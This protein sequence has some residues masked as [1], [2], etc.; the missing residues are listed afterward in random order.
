M[1][2]T[3]TASDASFTGP[4]LCRL[5]AR[6]VVGLLRRGEVAPAEVL[7]AALARID[8]VEPAI[9]ALPTVCA[10][11]ARDH[12]ARFDAV[13]TADRTAAGWLAGLPV[14]IKDLVEVAG[15]RSTS[16]TA[17][18][19]D[20]VPEVS[21]LLVERLEANGGVVIAKSNTPEMGAGGNTFNAVFGATRNPWNTA[22]NA[23]GSSGGAG[24]A[25]AAGEV[26]LAHGSDLAGSLRTPA[27]YCGVVGLRPT[28][29]RIA[30]GPSDNPFDINGVQGPM[31]RTVADTA[32]FL[33][34]MAGF[35]RRDPISFPSAGSFAD[36]VNCAKA[37]RRLAYSPDFD[38]F[39]A[40]EPEIDA[41]CRAAI[42][43]LQ[44][45]GTTVEDTC[46]HLPDLE[47]T[48]VTLRAL[49]W[50]AG[51]GKKPGEIQ[52]HFKRTLR[53][54]IELGRN[55]SVDQIVNAQRN[56]GLLYANMQKFFETFDVLA[57]PTI[58]LPPGPVEEEYPR[59]VAGASMHSYIDWLR[60]SFLATTAALPAI[61]IPVGF[62]SGGMPVGL[63]LIG[64]PRG[65]A[66]V[67]AVAAVIEADL[68]MSATPIDPRSG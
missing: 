34:C 33:D 68:G 47:E 9:N 17:G 29:G 64:P 5:S 36:A 30:R 27:A 67:L 42:D 22:R 66:I 11:R 43:R 59:A 23:G 28:P 45:L 37:P 35:D 25:L 62:D 41:V 39:A 48:Y 8:Q 61:S 53:E 60:F 51:P 21:N 19:S 55:L 18:L 26:W 38:G 65:E 32:L 2:D 12:L 4:E 7:D 3:S 10:G 6:E 20:H 57:C 50:A 15:V 16:G 52:R 44:P 63:Q 13:S 56:R 54:N 40:V 1:P 49:T 31:A 46:P 58:G 24:A 14:A